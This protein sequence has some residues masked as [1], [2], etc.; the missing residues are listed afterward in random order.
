M[1]T[2]NKIF[3]RNDRILINSLLVKIFKNGKED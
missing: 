3:I 2:V 1:D